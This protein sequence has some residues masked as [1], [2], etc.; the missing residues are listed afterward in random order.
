MPALDVVNHQ[1]ERV[2]EVHLDDAI[3]DGRVREHLV[4][5]VVVMQLWSALFMY[6]TM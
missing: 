5:E 2:G 1:N 3:F 4:H 6:T